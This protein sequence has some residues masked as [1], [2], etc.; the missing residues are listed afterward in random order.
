MIPTLNIRAPNAA[1]C[2]AVILIHKISRN[3]GHDLDHGAIVASYRLV[4]ETYI[5]GIGAMKKSQHV[6]PRE[7]GWAVRG[8]GN[9]RDTSRHR[10]QQEAF[11]RAREIAMN[12]RSEVFIHDRQGR[13]R[14]R[15]TYNEKDPFPPRG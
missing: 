10:T 4:I 11:E 8:A 1:V 15:N 7:N 12:Q 9:G 5:T 2:E 6:V 13:F 14:E 3:N